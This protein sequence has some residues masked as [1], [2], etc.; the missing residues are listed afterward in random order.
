MNNEGYVRIPCLDKN[1]DLKGMP[2]CTREVWFYILRKVSP[3]NTDYLKKGTGEFV[4]REVRK[5]LGW[6][7]GQRTKYYSH[8]QIGNAF[9]RLEALKLI[10]YK[11]INAQG[12]IKI[13]SPEDTNVCPNQYMKGKHY[14]LVTVFNYETY[15]V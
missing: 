14:K 6:N 1:P 13:I 5:D 7:I 12:Q 4:L 3:K 11:T 8:S 10:D 15:N 2:P 9:A